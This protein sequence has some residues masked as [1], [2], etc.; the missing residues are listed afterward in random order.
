[1]GPTPKPGMEGDQQAAEKDKAK[2]KKPTKKDKDEKS[3]QELGD[4]PSGNNENE[5]PFYQ[6]QGNHNDSSSA[7]AFDMAPNDMNQHQQPPPANDPMNQQVPF[8]GSMPPQNRTTPNLQQQQQH[9]QQMLHQQLQ[10]KQLEVNP[11]KL[12]APATPARPSPCSS[13]RLEAVTS[14]MEAL[15][16]SW[17]QTPES[18]NTQKMLRERAS[19][20]QYD[21]LSKIYALD[22]NED[23]EKR[24]FYDRYLAF[25]S[26]TGTPITKVPIVG[27]KAL[28]LYT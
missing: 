7:S 24:N 26:V 12:S 1:M 23:E 8:G 10:A 9:Q 27:K 13:P 5:N 17:P 18:P 28:D 22:M 2:K 20:N 21:Q 6:G 4:L 25:M 19:P 11:N 15:S 3:K 16:P 14:T